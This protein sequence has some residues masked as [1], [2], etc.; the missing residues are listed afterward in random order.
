MQTSVLETTAFPRYNKAPSLKRIYVLQ[1]YLLCCPSKCISDEGYPPGP[2]TVGW[3]C[4]CWTMKPQYFPCDRLVVSNLHSQPRA[5]ENTHNYCN[6]LP[7]LVKGRLVT[8]GGASGI[9]LGYWLGGSR[10]Y[11]CINTHVHY[12]LYQFEIQFTVPV[13]KLPLSEI[14]TALCHSCC[15][16]SYTQQKALSIRTAHYLSACFFHICRMRNQALFAWPFSR[17][18]V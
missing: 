4:T 1:S 6:I 18:K 15:V 9:Y 8:W 13:K 5:I 16:L 10:G 14:F 7:N 11:V 2:Q 3:E 12:L 17:I